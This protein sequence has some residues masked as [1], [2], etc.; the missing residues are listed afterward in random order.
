MKDT[1]LKDQIELLKIH[2]RYNH[3][4]SITGIELLAAVGYFPKRLLNCTRLA[5]AIYCYGA[6]QRRL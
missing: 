2:E 5:Y 3:V 4:I 6:T 1:L